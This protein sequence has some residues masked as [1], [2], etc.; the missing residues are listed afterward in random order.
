MYRDLL[1]TDY[2]T[3]VYSDLETILDEEKPNTRG[4]AEK[5]LDLRIDEIT[6]E[7]TGS[8]DCN[9]EKAKEKVLNELGMF[10]D[11]VSW[12]DVSSAEVGEWFLNERWETMDVLIRKYVYNYALND[13]LDLYTEFSEDD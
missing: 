9:T 5:V 1:L 12:Y 11:A 4:E 2:F 10:L 7:L 8:Y 13:M 3:E 6:G